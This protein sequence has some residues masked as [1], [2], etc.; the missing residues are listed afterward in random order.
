MNATEI[1][2][3]SLLAGIYMSR[4]LGLFLIFP[5][6][7]VLAQG[8]N[9]ATPGK[10]GLALGIY[11]LAQAVLQIPAGL[12]SDIIGR[13][14][15]L[16]AGLVL[17]FVGSVLAALTQDIHVLIIARLLQGMGAVSAVCLAYVGDSIRGNEQGKAMMIIGVSI[18]LAF[19]LSFV[20]GAVTSAFAGLSGLF[21]LTAILALCALG[22]AYA[23]PKPNQ[24]RVAFSTATF[25]QALNNRQLWAVNAQ[26]GVLHMLLAAS[27]FLLPLLLQSGL[28]ET[29]WVV[30]YLL[31]LLGALFVVAPLV[32][33]RDRG[34][35]LLPAF[36][37][38]FALSL[39]LLAV[40]PVF[41]AQIM[42]M[43]VLWVFFSGFTLVETLLPARL[44]QLTDPAMRGTTSGIFSVHQFGGNFLGGLLGAKCYTMF[45]ASGT[46][47][48]SFYVLAALA[49]IVVLVSFFKGKTKR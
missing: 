49:I 20:L 36:W 35:V 13:K 41:G 48:S 38:V 46:I 14:K 11:S 47:Q 22:F 4:M 43:L 40:L 29:N 9:N 44:F 32:R 37:A 24:H 27:F 26:I 18:G 42:F 17:F 25:W 16:Y 6:F 21:A 30:L 2:T 33:N 39:L 23:L 5:T 15:V 7:S 28:S 45:A 12:L 10:I 3:V 8:L 19:V 31:P 34:V 1:K